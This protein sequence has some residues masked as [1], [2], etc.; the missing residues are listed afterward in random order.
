MCDYTR[1]RRFENYA[2]STLGR[3]GDSAQTH[4]LVPNQNEFHDLKVE[5]ISSSRT[6]WRAELVV[7]SACRS[8][9]GRM[10][11]EGVLSLARAFVIAGVPC[12]VASLWE[13]LDQPTAALM[14]VMY[15]ALRDGND[16]DSTLR[17]AMLSRLATH[18]NQVHEWAPFNAWGV[19]TL[20]LPQALQKQSSSTL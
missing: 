5:D 3:S 9:R 17:A 7:L 12:V 10:T 1:E 11:A 14:A 15:D 20:C 6:K 18:R 16:I 2:A 8:S 13:V 4:S 19:P